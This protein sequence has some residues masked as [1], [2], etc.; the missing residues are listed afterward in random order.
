MQGK[1]IQSLRRDCGSSKSAS[2]GKLQGLG[3]VPSNNLIRNRFTH[4]RELF[5]A[6]AHGEQRVQITFSVLVVSLLFT[7]H[8][9]AVSRVTAANGTEAAA[10]K[11]LMLQRKKYDARNMIALE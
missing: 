6:H 10:R 2:G 4:V 9:T 3:N 7:D 11:G 5:R 8:Q 1:E